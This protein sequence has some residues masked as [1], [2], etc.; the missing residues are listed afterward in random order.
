M[1]VFVRIFIT[2]MI[3]LKFS[4]ARREKFLLFK[5]HG[6]NKK[7]TTNKKKNKKMQLISERDDCLYVFSMNKWKEYCEKLC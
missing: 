6:N 5:L 3:S 1:A 2:F 4:N 7:K